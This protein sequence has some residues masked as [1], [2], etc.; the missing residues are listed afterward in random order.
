LLLKT[1]LLREKGNGVYSA[2][3]WTVEEQYIKYF[4][5]C[6]E[7]ICM[8]WR[9]RRLFLTRFYHSGHYWQLSSH[10]LDE[11]QYMLHIDAFRCENASAS[12]G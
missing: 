9:F 4:E 1:S 2:Y 7:H 11:D 10:G 5:V 6:H 8:E 12:V 3:S